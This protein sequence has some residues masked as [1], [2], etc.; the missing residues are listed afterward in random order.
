VAALVAVAAVQETRL[1]LLRTLALVA[2]LAAAL[3][4]SVIG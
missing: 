4:Y 3:V 2:A 1:R